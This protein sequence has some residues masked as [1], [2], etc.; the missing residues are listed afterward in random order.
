VFLIV[1]AAGSYF[2]EAAPPKIKLLRRLGSVSL[3]GGPAFL[4]IFFAQKGPQGVRN[5]A[6]E[7]IAVSLEACLFAG[8]LFGD[9]RNPWLSEGV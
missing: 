1:L 7:L 6:A 8:N 5:T 2:L 3:Q 4:F 9:K